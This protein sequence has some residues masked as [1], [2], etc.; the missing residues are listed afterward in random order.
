MKRKLFFLLAALLTS[1]GMYAQIDV[2]S[3]YL[4]NP[5][6]ETGDMTGWSSYG[7]NPEGSVGVVD[8]T[9]ESC[10][11]ADYPLSNSDGTYICNFYKEGWTGWWSYYTLSQDAKVL[12]AGNYRLT[13]VLSSYKDRVVSLYATTSP[14]A[15]STGSAQIANVTIEENNAGKTATLDFTSDGSTPVILGAGLIT[16]GS[17]SDGYP[18]VWDVFFK[19]DNFKL[20][21]LATDMS[22]KMS[23]DKD[24]WTGVGSQVK[25]AAYSD[26]VE[27]YQGNTTQFP[28]GDVLYQTI[29][30]LPNGIYEVSFYAWENY[31]NH[32]E[33]ESIKYGDGYAQAF[34]NGSIYNLNSIK[35]TNGRAWDT[36]LYTLK[37]YVTDGTI[38]YGVKNVRAGG[39]WVVCKKNSLK[40]YGADITDYTSL[41]SNA[42]FE[43]SYAA[44]SNS[45]RGDSNRE[46]YIPQNWSVTYTG[47][48]WS[49]SALKTGDKAWDDNFKGKTQPADGGS[50]VFWVRLRDTNDA[51]TLSQ[52]IALPAGLY[53]LN[54]EGYND[55]SSNGTAAISV[56]YDSDKTNSTAFTSNSWTYANVVFNLATAQSVVIS[57]KAKSTSGI[58]IVGVDNF[59]LTRLGD[60]LVAGDDATVIIKDADCSS[61]TGWPG[62]GREL[63]NMVAYDGTTRNVFAS[64]GYINPDT[65]DGQRTQTITIPVTGAYK[66]TTYSKV[67]GTNNNGYVKI[68]IGDVGNYVDHVAARHLYTVD[69][70]GDNTSTINSDG[71]RWVANDIYFTASASDSK[72]IYIN[73]SRGVGTGNYEYA[74]VSGMKLT[75]LGTTP[76]V[77]FDEAVM[78]PV[79]EEDLE[80][81]N[82][83]IA[84]KLKSDRWNTFTVPFNM[85]IPDGWTVKELTKLDFNESTSNYSLT[86]EAASNIVAGK[87]YMV[88]PSSDVSEVS[89]SG[90]TINTSTVTSSEVSDGNY[91][92]DFVGNNSYIT[93]VPMDSYI[94]SNNVFYIVDSS[95]IQKGFRGYITVGATTEARPTVTFS[96]D[97]DVTGI[98]NVVVSGLDEPSVQK[99]GKYLEAGKIVI[100]RNGVKYSANGQILK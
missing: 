24:K 81:A 7:Y 93:E 87:A 75:Y 49:C 63:V 27:T 100:V 42:D 55:A 40:Y 2:T 32:T 77:S 74:Y 43:G 61:N 96:M 94:I 46:I 4:T 17:S 78:N 10:P 45:G 89:A 90:V 51:L 73:I 82:V 79:I 58:D 95:I 60:A 56:T 85:D 83:T 36:N 72:I 15:T 99:D 22:D 13:A 18:S 30:G 53:T 48:G 28:V 21:R 41:I 5:S 98:Q 11:V 86:F 91:F 64:N 12:P 33:T 59:S 3:K 14:I 52:T 47:G 92:A 66:L 88:K 76:A 54:A 65:K 97:E 57:Y 1:V 80:N 44:M 8:V 25:T 9:G 38:K 70:N 50:K 69:T 34:A 39:N 6:F 26:G 37:C 23:N 71:S 62:G 29:T 20:Y 84:R 68:W 16:N 31:A 19:A 35:S 67:T